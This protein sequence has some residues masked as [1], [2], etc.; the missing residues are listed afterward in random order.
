MPEIE[1]IKDICFDLNLPYDEL[2]GDRLS[3]KINALLKK[4][5]LPVAASWWVSK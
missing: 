1:E 3:S 4:C 2:P 5:Q